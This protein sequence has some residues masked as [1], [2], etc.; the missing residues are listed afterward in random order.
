[1]IL[2]KQKALLIS[3]LAASLFVGCGDDKDNSNNNGG[4]KQEDTSSCGN[5]KIDDGEECDGENLNDKTCKTVSDAFVS[6]KLSCNK[7]CKFDKTE[8]VACTDSDKSKCGPEQIC[9][10]GHCEDKDYQP[11]CGNSKIDENE[12]CEG[13]KVEGKTCKD[14]DAKAYVGGE[15]KCD[16][17]SFDV[18]GCVQCTDEDKS[19]CK[20]NQICKDGKCVKDNTGCVGD[21]CLACDGPS[22]CAGREDGKTFCDKGTCVVPTEENKPKVVISQIYTAGGNKGA[23]Y[24]TKYVELLNIG[25]SEID[26]SNWSLQY[27]T[28]SSEKVSNKCALPDNAKIPKGGFYLIALKSGSNGLELITPDHTCSSINPAADKG[29]IY[30]VDNAELLPSYNPTS[31]YIDAVGYGSANW[32]EGEPM[33]ALSVST[34]GFRKNDGC[35]DTNDNAN[36]FETASPLPRNSSSDKN[37]CDGNYTKPEPSSNCEVEGQEFVAKYSKCAYPLSTKDDIMNLSANW[38]KYTANA[39]GVKEFFIKDN[40]DLGEI[41]SKTNIVPVLSKAIIYGNNKTITSKFVISRGLFGKIEESSIQ[42]LTFNSN[43]SS[44]SFALWGEDIDKSTFNNITFTGSAV[45]NTTKVIDLISLDLDTKYYGMNFGAVKDSTLETILSDMTIENTI[46]GSPYSSFSG[47]VF[48][49]DN[50]KANN[51]TLKGTMNLQC[52]NGQVDENASASQLRDK[53][54]SVL[55][56]ETYNNNNSI[57]NLTIETHVN[58]DTGIVFIYDYDGVIDRVLFKPTLSYTFNNSEFMKAYSKLTGEQDECLD[59]F[60]SFA[61]QEGDIISNFDDRTNDIHVIGNSI[62]KIANSRIA[63]PSVLNCTFA[64]YANVIMPYLSKDDNG[65]TV[66][67]GQKYYST[68]FKED[69]P[70][71]SAAILNKN[72]KDKKEG[73]PSGTY[74]PWIE[75]SSHELHLNFDATDAE[76]IVVP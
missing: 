65:S 66:C 73:I 11:G 10:N 52:I 68:Y 56:G 63:M 33:A 12:Q 21:E 6:G 27:G 69:M 26:I 45:L 50:V 19:L 28:A 23:V 35:T 29:K 16:E 2:S 20:E 75:D 3:L 5:G 15:L 67:S 55:L 57:T 8:C 40:I 34:A 72:L 4:K 61:H 58:S 44:N 41:T 9:S 54:K 70:V 25:D 48:S 60:V 49:F 1:M 32:A 59:A 17:C 43:N 62:N 13:T 37:L 22:D 51:I 42:D 74:L 47:F 30:L 14:I 76:L 18:T 7:S 46:Q 24:N 38:D 39:E 64:S 31:G 36:D 53:C 71:V